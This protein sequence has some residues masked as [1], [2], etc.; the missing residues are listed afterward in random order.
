[1]VLESLWSKGHARNTRNIFCL[2]LP[3]GTNPTNLI[4]CISCF[5]NRKLYIFV[6]VLEMT[7]VL[8]IVLLVLARKRFLSHLIPY[9]RLLGVPHNVPNTWQCRV[10]V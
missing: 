10:F 8:G 5:Q 6:V 2:Q 1:M 9:L 3:E 4:F 7:L